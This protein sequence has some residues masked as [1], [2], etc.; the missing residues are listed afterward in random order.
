MQNY[1]ELLNK[2]IAIAF[3]AHKQQ[4]DKNGEPYILHLSRVMNMGKNFEEKI[5]G[6]LH[7][8]VEDSDWTFEQLENEG[9]PHEIVDALK[10]LTK[11]AEEE[12]YD[13][14]INR[15]LQN[16]LAI[17]VKINDLTDNLD[18]KRMSEVRNENLKRINKYLKAY[19][20]LTIERN[21][22]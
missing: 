13:E 2:A 17:S 11:L 4:T 12:D 3:E 15:V 9:F 21:K 5:C 8:L 20:Y 19:K 7:D 6:I 16:K 22:N 10:C 14:F 18:I 1:N